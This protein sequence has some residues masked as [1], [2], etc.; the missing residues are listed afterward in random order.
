MD[1]RQAS[2]KLS[3]VIDILRD[4]W[5]SKALD[6]LVGINLIEVKQY[7]DALGSAA[8]TAA[9]PKPNGGKLRGRISK[10]EKDNVALR[11][12]LGGAS[13]V[14]SDVVEIGGTSNR[15]VSAD[16][17]RRAREVEA[18]YLVVGSDLLIRKK[19]VP[20]KKK[21]KKKAKKASKKGKK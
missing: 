14:V 16:V 17:L 9:A 12:L 13:E 21:G 1:S 11:K 8:T 4:D 5:S 3:L 15:Y 7:I 6:Q 2:V 20:A 10:L 19:K 18:E